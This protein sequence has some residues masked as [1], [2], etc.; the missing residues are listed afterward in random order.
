VVTFV[1]FVCPT[2]VLLCGACAK[3]SCKS[4]EN[5]VVSK[6]KGELILSHMIVNVFANCRRYGVISAGGGPLGGDGFILC[7]VS[8]TTTLSSSLM[9]LFLSSEFV[10]MIFHS[11]KRSSGIDGYSR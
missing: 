3:V 1:S 8:E 9:T 11:N 6:V 7:S 10:A 5:C 2:A 4:V